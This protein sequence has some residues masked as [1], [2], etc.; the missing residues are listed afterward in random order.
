MA[1]HLAHAMVRPIRDES[2]AFYIDRDAN[3]VEELRR[4]LLLVPAPGSVPA[5]AHEHERRLDAVEVAEGAEWVA[6][7]VAEWQSEWQ[8]E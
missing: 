2:C 7:W 1:F 4:L 6:R 5:Q 8:S 3:G